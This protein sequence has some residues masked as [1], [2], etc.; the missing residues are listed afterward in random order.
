MR[1]E[2]LVKRVREGVKGEGER[3]GEWEREREREK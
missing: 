1:G 2:M 3:G